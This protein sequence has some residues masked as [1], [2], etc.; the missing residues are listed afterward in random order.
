VT[1]DALFS[2]E[3]WYDRV[4]LPG[5]SGMAV[6]PVL[7]R[8]GSA[9]IAAL[10]EATRPLITPGTVKPGILH[11]GLGAFHRA[12]QAVYTEEAIA[13]RGGDWA[14]V[15][16]A[17]RSRQLV[18]ILRD[19]DNLFSVSSL[20]GDAATTRVIGALAGVRH[21]P[22]QA[23]DI[24]D[25][26]ADPDIRVVTITVT[27]KGYRLDPS[28]G[29]PQIDDEV[30]ADL[31]TS[32]DPR[33]V[34]GLLIR[35]MR[36]RIAAGSPPI[37]L[38]SC[39][40]LP[41]NGV[42]LRSLVE[43]A[44]GGALGNWVSFPS[45]MVDRIVPST[46]PATLDRAQRALGRTDL[47]AVDAEPY[48][49]WVIEDDF[50]A[51]RP[52][53]YAAG[54]V[55]TSDVTTWERLKLRVL[56]GVHSTLAYL[57]A[58]AGCRTVAETMALPGMESLLTRLVA[59]DIAPTVDPP[60]GVTVVDYGASVLT[61]FANPAIAHR[62]LQVAMDGSQKLPQRLL[63]TLSERRAAGAMPGYGALAVAAWMRFVLGVADNGT[64]LPLDDPL[65]ESIRAVLPTTGDPVRLVRGLL[66][67]DTGFP[68]S[69]A[70]DDD[71]IAVLTEWLR[72]LGANGAAAT[73]RDAT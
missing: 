5:R 19:Q 17:P 49:Q 23:P 37:A 54:A 39:D 33:T 9:A 29:Q 25:L 27:E 63:H 15:A 22:T 46:T 30:R 18:D 32:R 3:E 36:A 40:N 67:L 52:A 20:A 59:D 34:P 58:L 62:T 16:V 44:M 26:F 71:L 8:L 70:G 24:L 66:S 21:L 38:V 28:T 41:S 45:T 69:F 48:R 14:I 1:D 43:H 64:A 10:P 55:L 50:P 2:A 35:G 61:R 53:W 73:V 31:E 13:A 51:G 11:V 42:R 4:L 72:L 6:T 57:G 47:A 65:A 7:S 60:P 56:N 12:H 68:P